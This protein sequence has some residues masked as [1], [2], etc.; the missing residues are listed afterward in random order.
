M[1]WSDNDYEHYREPNEV[2]ELFDEA[3]EKLVGMLKESVKEEMMQ[4][5]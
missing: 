4:L 5:K 3:K 1:E 2:E